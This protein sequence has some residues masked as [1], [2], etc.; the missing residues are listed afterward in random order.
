MDDAWVR[1]DIRGGY[2]QMLSIH[3]LRFFADRDSHFFVFGDI[4]G[5]F[6]G[7]SRFQPKVL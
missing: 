2:C 3:D 7:A 5:G 1:G 6:A 4:G